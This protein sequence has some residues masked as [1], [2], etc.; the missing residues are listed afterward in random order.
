MKNIL[1]LQQENQKE[2]FRK[3]IKPFSSYG[4]SKSVSFLMI[5]PDWLTLA[6]LVRFWLLNILS[7]QQ[8]LPIYLK[9]QK[10]SRVY[11]L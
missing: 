1:R 4:T 5:N 3:N 9:G 2:N 7:N 11:S 6:F 8:L 10:S